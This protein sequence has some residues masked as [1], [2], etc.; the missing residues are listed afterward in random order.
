MRVTALAICVLVLALCASGALAQAGKLGIGVHGSSVKS[1]TEEDS[2]YWTWGVHTRVRFSPRLA[3]E[4]SLEFRS[5]E[6]DGADIKLYPIQVSALFYL[7]PSSRAG[8]YGI[9]G[10]GWTRVT[11]DGNI[12]GEGA[13]DTDFGYHWGFGAEVPFGSSTIF[14]DV[15]YLDLKLGISNLLN[16]NFD[17]KGWQANTGYTLYF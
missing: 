7:L 9:L 8:I 11:V 1:A 13:E 10:F 2:R 5:E 6:V 17:T 14:V 3:L 15:R 16:P 4:G 12:F